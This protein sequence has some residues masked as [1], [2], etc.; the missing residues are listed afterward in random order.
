MVRGPH[1][2]QLKVTSEVIFKHL[3][4]GTITG[5]KKKKES[6]VVKKTVTK[7]TPCYVL[8]KCLSSS[9][10]SPSRWWQP[11]GFVIP[12][13]TLNTMP[14][15]FM[16]QFAVPGDRSFVL[17]SCCFASGSFSAMIFILSCANSFARTQ[18]GG[19]CRGSTNGHLTFASCFLFF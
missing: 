15:L 12:L 1:K 3:Q 9:L 8:I 11:G 6:P 13:Y 4:I 5:Q 16:I 10:V 18:K 17:I 19:G 14:S 2:S 7:K